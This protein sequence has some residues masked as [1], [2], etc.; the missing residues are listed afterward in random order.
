MTADLQHAASLKH[1]DP[2][3]SALRLTVFHPIAN[4]LRPINISI[5]APDTITDL[6]LNDSQFRF[7]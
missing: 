4:A 2:L 6:P 5:R 3:A 7:D 1:A